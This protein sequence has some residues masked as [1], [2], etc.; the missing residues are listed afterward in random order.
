[1]RQNKAPFA[2]TGDAPS[3]VRTGNSSLMACRAA[4]S[5]WAAMARSLQELPEITAK[6]LR[7]FPDHK[8]RTKA[9]G[10]SVSIVGKTT[11]RISRFCK[12]APGSSLPRV[13]PVG[14]ALSF[15]L[16]TARVVSRLRQGCDGTVDALL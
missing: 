1:V 5:V 15:C 9:C 4:A 16:T 11:R 10:R 8:K 6:G 14:N 2:K 12:V 13:L 3:F 7:K